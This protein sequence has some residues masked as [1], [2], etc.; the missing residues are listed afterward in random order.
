MKRD[1]RKAPT[2]VH[3]PLGI[4]YHPNKEAKVIADCLE[5]QFTSHDLCNET[6][7]RQAET[8]VQA[9][10]PSEDCTPMG[11]VGPRDI[12]ILANSLKIAKGL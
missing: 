12:H 5:N 2:T 11:K 3:G 1:G 7:G 9:L 6:Y 8:R 10:L 4:T